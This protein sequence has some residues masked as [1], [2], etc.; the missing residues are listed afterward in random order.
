MC[1]ICEQKPVYEFTNKRK[2]CKNC[3]IK[4][5]EKKFLYTIRKYNLINKNET[6]L[7]KFKDN[8]RDAVLFYLLDF[9]SK[10]NNVRII[11]NGKLK[12]HQPFSSPHSSMDYSRVNSRPL[13]P[14]CNKI[15]ISN[16]LDL[17]SYGFIKL[18]RNKLS[19][20]RLSNFL[21]VRK[22]IIQPLFF[23][24]DKEILLYAELKGLKYKKE[25][26][27]KNNWNEFIDELEKKHPEIK[28]ALMNSYLKI[29]FNKDI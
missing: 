5:F 20:Q 22:K 21:P 16:S 7:I 11:K 18:L 3:Y 23:F 25:K 26:C 19:K 27:K 13:P 10:Q 17:N 1:H 15:A 6:I 9:Y 8:F 4:W 29:L 28:N 12:S 14:T 2:L 24:L